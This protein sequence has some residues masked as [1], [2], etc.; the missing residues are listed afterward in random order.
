MAA[1]IDD[2]VSMGDIV[3]LYEILVE[4]DDWMTQLDAAEGLAKLRDKRGLEFLISA[5]QSEEEQ[6]REVAKE[7]LNSPEMKRR[8]DDLKADEEEQR[9][10]RIETAKRRLQKGKK[11][12]RYKM[13]Y[14][15]AGDILSEDPLSQGFEIPALDEF[16]FEGWEVV[17]VIPRR[18][19]LLSSAVDDHFTGAYFL[20]KR[21]VTPDESA[22][23]D[24]A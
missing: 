2:L 18:R 21:E 4:D 1:S 11:V 24:K 12:F 16:G 13:V 5:E 3:S 23:L 22:D 15:P 20:L 14:M 6:I 17:N 9:Q 19:Q 10:E 7:I 8:L